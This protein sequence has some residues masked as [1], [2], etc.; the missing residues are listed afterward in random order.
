MPL[1][2]AIFSIVRKSRRN[3]HLLKCAAQR[4]TN[5]GEQYAVSQLANLG[6]T[7]CRWAGCNHPISNSGSKS[8]ARHISNHISRSR[9]NHCW[10]G[11][12][13]ETAE[14]KRSLLLHVQ[15]THGLYADATLPVEVNYCYECDVWATC[16]TTWELHCEDHLANLDL[17]CGRIARYGLT[18][19]AAQCPFCLGEDTSPSS[20]RLFQFTDMSHLRRH[21]NSVHLAK[22]VTWPTTC[23]HPLCTDILQSREQLWDHL[24]K[25]HSI[26]IGVQMTESDSG[27]Q[28]VDEDSGVC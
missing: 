27:D 10:W 2:P 15:C 9:T 26:S 22:T 8:V 24:S 17:F 14:N 16:R 28:E 6:L 7:H 18:I 3:E 4:K 11:N 25:V 1:T 23:P 12:C 19:I 5:E 13:A 21:I 20:Q